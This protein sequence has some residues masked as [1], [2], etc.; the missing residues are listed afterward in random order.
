M[1]SLAEINLNEAFGFATIIAAIDGVKDV[2]SKPLADISL[3]STLFFV[4]FVVFRVKMYL[5]DDAHDFSQGGTLDIT[6]ALLS[7]IFFLIS[8]ASMDDSV[9]VAIQWFI[10]A[11]LVSTVWTVWSL[12]RQRKEPCARRR[13]IQFLLF[14]LFHI[15]LLVL[16][17]ADFL[18]FEPGLGQDWDVGILVLLTAAVLVDWRLIV[19]CKK[20]GEGAG[21]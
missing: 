12:I 21:E 10:L 4:Y 14:N 2:F 19:D 8:A 1:K 9:R 16:L 15:G 20:I 18:W 13:N 3:V 17:T 5:D 7:W 6:I 11:L